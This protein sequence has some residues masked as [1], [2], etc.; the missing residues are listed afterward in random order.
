[1]SNDALLEA[2][3]SEARRQ[4]REVD[5]RLEL[6]VRRALPEGEARKLRARAAADPALTLA[7]E[8]FEPLSEHTVDALV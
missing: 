5:P 2:L 3:G 1:M 8:L 4:V 7:V 6:L